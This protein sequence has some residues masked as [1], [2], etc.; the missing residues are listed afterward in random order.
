MANTTQID[1]IRHGEPEGGQRYRGYGVDD[2]LTETGW[3]QMWDAVQH[4][5]GWSHIAT[6]PLLRCCAFAEA[7]AA[8]HGIKFSIDDR[9]KEIG[10]GAWEG[11]TPD[12]IIAADAGA[13]DHFYEDPVNNRPAGAEPL[14]TFSERVWQAYSDISEQ[15]SGGHIL[16]VGHAGVAR[17]VAANILGMQLNDVYS[18][19]QIAYGGIISTQI[20]AGKPPKVVISS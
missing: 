15:H 1:V 3:Q 7:L 13:L 5:S 16:I 19:L 8:K 10:F 6:S 18:R 14:D 2:P 12:E 4:L 9:L 17:A 20:V 11:K